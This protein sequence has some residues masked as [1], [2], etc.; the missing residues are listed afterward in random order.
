MVM[1]E[2]PFGELELS[3]YGLWVSFW[4]AGWQPVFKFKLRLQW[5]NILQKDEAISEIKTLD[6]EMTRR[7]VDKQKRRTENETKLQIWP[8]S[9]LLDRLDLK[10][11]IQ[12]HS[13]HKLWK[14]SSV[15]NTQNSQSRNTRPSSK[16]ILPKLNSYKTNGDGEKVTVKQGRKVALSREEGDED[17]DRLSG[18]DAQW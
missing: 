13:H 7:C 3:S 1:L 12:C 10:R 11:F 4:L 17:D 9:P 16:L 6:D 15:S 2:L 14:S 18:F 5:W 8:M